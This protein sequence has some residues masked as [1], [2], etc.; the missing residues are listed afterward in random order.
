MKK[1]ITNEN[2][3]AT[4][5]NWLEEL[6]TP[7]TNI[8]KQRQGGGGK[9][10]NYIEGKWYIERLNSVIGE[11]WSWEVVSIIPTGIS[12][13]CHGRLTING[14]TRDGIGGND[15][16][17]TKDKEKTPINVVN[18]GFENCIKSAETDAFKRACEKFNLGLFLSV[19]T[20]AKAE[21]Q[22]ITNTETRLEDF[23]VKIRE[24]NKED[25]IRLF[26][27]LPKEAKAEAKKYSDEL[28]LLNIK[29]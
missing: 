27:L 4:K 28:K 2:I 14:V 11:N 22:S 10:L 6:G 9:Q 15:L 13:I 1:Q 7:N 19:T 26:T 24:G 23:K 25:A 8:V 17:F 3:I 5:V 18:E 16:K 20:E 21:A 29:N 12:Y